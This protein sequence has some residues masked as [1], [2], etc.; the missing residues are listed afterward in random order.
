MSFAMAMR[1]QAAAEFTMMI[2]DDEFMMTNL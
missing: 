1:R 2:Y